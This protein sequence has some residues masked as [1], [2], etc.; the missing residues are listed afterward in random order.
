MYRKSNNLLISL[1]LSC[2]VAV[3]GCADTHNHSD[4]GHGEDHHGAGEHGHVPLITNLELDLDTVVAGETLSLSLTTD[5]AALGEEVMAHVYLNDTTTAPIAMGEEAVFFVTIPVETHAGSHQLVVRLHHVSD[6]TPLEPEV[7]ATAPLL[8]KAAPAA[9]FLSTDAAG[10]SWNATALAPQERP[11]IIEEL[12][13][14]ELSLLSGSEASGGNGKG[15]SWGDVI[16]DSHS[17]RI[18]ANAKNVDKVAVLDVAT[19]SMEAVLDVGERP[20]HLWSP[21]HNGEI[22]THADGPGEFYVIDPISLT[23]SEPVTAALDETG[24]HGKL[25]YAE[26]LGTQYYATNTN[27]PG[28]FPINGDDK[29]TSEMVTLCDMPCADDSETVGD[30]SLLTCGSTHDKAYNPTM[31]YGVF[32]CSG[33]ARG[34]YAFLDTETNTVVE[35]LVAINGSI[36]HSEGNEYILVIDAGAESDQV[37]IWDTG[38]ATHNGIEFDAVVT[39]D[40]EPSARGTQFREDRGGKWEAWIPQT[41]GTGLAV[42]NLETLAVEMIEIGPLTKPEGARHFS[43]RAVIGGDWLFTYNDLGAVMVNLDTRVVTQGPAIPGSVARIVFA[44]NE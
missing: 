37:K 8:V 43:R 11:R 44:G 17:G 13:L 36:T 12:S 28:V 1:G 21:N 19:R 34:K 18:F 5:H 25:L 15:A 26:E 39:L 41:A 14:N 9:W 23:V 6:H 20:V 30:E 2:L 40:G 35:D 29:T 7:Q 38:S 32:Q 31:G 4:H 22:W 42:V 3:A 27:N 10:N 16:W 33:A 24:G